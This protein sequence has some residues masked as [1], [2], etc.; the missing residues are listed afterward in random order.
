MCRKIDMSQ[1]RKF[2]SGYVSNHDAAEYSEFLRVFRLEL[3]AHYELPKDLPRQ[4]RTLM[5]ALN[6]QDERFER[7]REA[8]HAFALF[9]AGVM[10][11]TAVWNLMLFFY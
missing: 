10:V 9:V 2:V 6:G 4:I 11:V 8:K 1:Q 3:L 7:S 5:T